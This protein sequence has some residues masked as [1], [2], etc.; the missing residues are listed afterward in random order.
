MLTASLYKHQCYKILSNILKFNRQKCGKV[1]F[2][3]N[4]ASGMTVLSEKKEMR[5]KIESPKG[6][7]LIELFIN[8][9][10]T[11]MISLLPSFE[12]TNQMSFFL[13]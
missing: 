6:K 9:R 1:E 11:G 7:A 10:E 13:K 3:D 4:F 5:I 8:N 12:A 2:N